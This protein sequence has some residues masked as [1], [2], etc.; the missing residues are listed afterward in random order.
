[1]ASVKLETLW[2]ND[3]ADLSDSQSFITM[4]GLSASVQPRVEARMM[5]NGST[6]KVT[7][8]GR[9]RGLVAALPLLTRT[10]VR[11]LE[12]KAGR[13]LL[14]RDPTGRKFYGFFTGPDFNER[15]WDSTADTALTFFE[16][17]YGEA[18]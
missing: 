6:R 3:A 13:L 5:A 18:V 2:L 4:N 9:P 8:V 16:I 11:W 12:D 1:M 15:V 7:R 10:Q 17:T 14:V